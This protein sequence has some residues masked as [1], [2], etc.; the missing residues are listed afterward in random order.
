MEHTD[1]GHALPSTD[2]EVQLFLSQCVE[3]FHVLSKCPQGAMIQWILACC[4]IGEDSLGS[5]S[6]VSWRAQLH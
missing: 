1:L 4:L 5:L 6:S 3:E 2:N